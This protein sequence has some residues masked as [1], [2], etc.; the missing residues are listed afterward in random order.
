M[1][2]LVR[3]SYGRIPHLLDYNR[4][5][6]LVKY[7]VPEIS[8]ITEKVNPLDKKAE[9]KC[10]I[11][12]GTRKQPHRRHTGGQNPQVYS[13]NRSHIPST[14]TSSVSHGDV[15]PE[16]DGAETGK[17]NKCRPHQTNSKNTWL[18]DGKSGLSTSNF[19]GLRPKRQSPRDSVCTKVISRDFFHMSVVPRAGFTRVHFFPRGDSIFPACVSPSGN[20]PSPFPV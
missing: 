2:I 17:F 14:I 8:P 7:R 16:Y 5:R 13:G 9:P 18:C 4:G 15:V 10:S 12:T 1:G 20:A 6:Y 11:S 3:Y 19:F